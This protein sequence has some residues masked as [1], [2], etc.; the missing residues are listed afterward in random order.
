MEGV[1][2]YENYNEEY[3]K[4]IYGIDLCLYIGPFGKRLN[5]QRIIRQCIA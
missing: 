1:V 5:D 4:V 2:R 3:I